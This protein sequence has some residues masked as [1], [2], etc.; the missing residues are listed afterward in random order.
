M[1]AKFAEVLRIYSGK[2]A[3]LLKSLLGKI[4]PGYIENKYTVHGVLLAV[5]VLIIITIFMTTRR[6]SLFSLHPVCMVI[7][8][9]LFFGEGIVSYKNNFMVESLGPIMQHNKTSKVGIV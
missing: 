6:L 1:E 8:C 9:I 5:V 3:Q 7:G 4:P 2:R